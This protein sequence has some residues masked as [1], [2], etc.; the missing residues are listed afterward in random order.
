MGW[1]ERLAAS[2]VWTRRSAQAR[3][4]MLASIA[5][6][7]LTNRY[8]VCSLCGINDREVQP[9]KTGVSQHRMGNTGTGDSSEPPVFYKQPRLAAPLIRISSHRRQIARMTPRPVTP[10]PGPTSPILGPLP[11]HWKLPRTKSHL[12]PD[13]MR[14]GQK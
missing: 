10:I 8:S 14:P 11:A 6:N 3:Q 9:C 1:K 2:C 12:G 13:R 4:P 7:C 5:K